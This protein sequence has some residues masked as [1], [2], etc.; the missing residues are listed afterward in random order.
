[1]GAHEKYRV[2][3]SSDENGRVFTVEGCQPMTTNSWLLPHFTFSQF[4]LRSE[5]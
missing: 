1:M 3:T 5:R 4:L 2:T